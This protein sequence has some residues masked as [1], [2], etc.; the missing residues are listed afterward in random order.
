[1]DSKPVISLFCNGTHHQQVRFEEIGSL[2]FKHMAKM[3]CE[4]QSRDCTRRNIATTVEAG[5]GYR[6]LGTWVA[7]EIPE[8]GHVAEKIEKKVSTDDF[9]EDLI[10]WAAM[11]TSEGCTAVEEGC[12]RMS[13]EEDFAGGDH[14]IATTGLEVDYMDGEDLESDNHNSTVGPRC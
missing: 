2:E 13:V 11:Q 12:G 9:V 3:G 1:M 8:E 4:V 5:A 10:P 14:W 6:A 7:E